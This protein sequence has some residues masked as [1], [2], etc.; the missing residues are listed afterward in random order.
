MIALLIKVTILLAFGGMVAA[1]LHKASAALRH[2]VWTLTLA[3]S[4][5]IALATPIAPDLPLSIAV[6]SLRGS[7]ATEAISIPI[8]SDPA[9]VE[10]TKSTTP[11]GAATSITTMPA[12][13]SI[14][15][16]AIAIWLLGAL[17]VLARY[18]LGHLGLL[19][20]Q[21]RATPLSDPEWQEALAAARAE[22]R[23]TRT[24]CLFAARAVGS[25]VTWGTRRPVVLLPDHATSWPFER[26]RVVLA[27]E[28]AHA[29]RGDYLAQL[30]ACV[31]CALY[32]FHP[33]VWL[34]ARRLRSE[35]ERAADDLV[36]Q[37]GIRPA[38]YA[39]HLLDIATSARTLR[40]AGTAAIGMARPSHLEGRLLA[41][42]DQSRS[43]LAPPARA[44][45]AAWA[46]LLL[47]V[48]P[49]AAL[50]PMPRAVAVTN[51]SPS[52]R[53]SGATVVVADSSPSSP[54]SPFSPEAGSGG[55]DSTFETT[56]PA[57]P[58]GELVLELETGGDVYIQGWDEPELR[59][60][61]RL[62]GPNWRDTRVE[63]VKVPPIRLHTFQAVERRTSSTSHHFDIRVPRRFDLRINSAGGQVTIVDLEGEFRGS[64]GGGGFVIEHARGRANLTTGGGD[65]RVNDV[66]MDGTVST[67]GGMITLSRVRGGL[68][69]SSG[70]G[71]V[72]STGAG[73]SAT[74]SLEHVTVSPDKDRIHVGAR[75]TTREGEMLR[76]RK[77]GGAIVLDR[78]PYGADLETG[79]GEIRVGRSAGQVSA[80][81]GGGDITIGP[82]AGSV[83]AG[84]GAGT[85][86]VT[87]VEA[88][89]Q[90]GE[91][92][93]EIDAGVGSVILELPS[94][95][96]GRLDLETAYTRNFGRRTRINSDWDVPEVETDDWDPTEGTPRKYVRA[97]GRIGSA[98]GLV[99]IKV[100]NGDI[101]IRRSAP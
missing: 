10:D 64:T 20:L 65:I 93:V 90:G 101:T 63:L 98:G 16:V 28:L 100:V 41:V 35:S 75:A 7:G 43:R 6:P 48:L 91:Q 5:A 33:L 57:S 37:R 54:F 58:G 56:F 88:G 72:I 53:G 14:A 74:G 89:G 92:S 81:T 51:L 71:P 31:A 26:R 3:G 79:G 87:V 59:I 52:L 9:S 83:R 82:V 21:R 30:I 24:V 99:R 55:V 4:L 47:L 45:R 77:A 36:L 8:T 32:W 40:L 27:H 18:L 95:F 11:V 12:G 66:D 17:A 42:L 78:A 2:L 38:D 25:P 76:V 1:S 94:S 70:S 73:A 50:R 68:R 13:L 46:G 84:T 39:A 29:A 60:R 97:S 86:H 69:G 22:Y 49:L 61:G 15:Q 19:L 62:G 67:G 44:H 23:I 34:A 85:V 96:A 80:S